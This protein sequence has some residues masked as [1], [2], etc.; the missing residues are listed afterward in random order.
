VNCHYK[1]F[2]GMP[3][4]TVSATEANRR[5]SRLLRDVESGGRVTITKDGRPVAILAPIETDERQLS[6]NALERFRTLLAT[7]LPI[8]FAGGLDRDALHRR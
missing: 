1:E 4:G 3:D 5:F 2:A 8:G 7:G 6:P